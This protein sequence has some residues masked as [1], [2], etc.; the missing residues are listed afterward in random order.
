MSENKKRLTESKTF[1]MM[2]WIHMHGF[3]DGRVYP[4]CFGDYHQPLGNLRENT[5][6]EVW[7][8]E[9][10]KEL[11]KNMLNE[12]PSSVCAKCY[13]QEGTG[14]FSLRNSINQSH[15]KY[16]DEVDLTHE[17]GFHPEF[18]LRYWDVRFSNLCNFSCRSCSPVFSSN[19]FKEHVKMYGG[20]PQVDGRELNVVE[21][22]G[23]TKYDIW[24]QM[25]P[26]IPY[27]DQIYFAGGEPLIM[28]EHYM[29]LE[30]L[31]ELGK[32]DINLQYNTNFS[33]MSFKNKDVI[34]LWKQ[35]S[36]VNVGASL[37]G[38]HRR[39]ELIRRGQNWE[40]TV[41]NRRRMIEEVPHV[42]FHISATVSIMNVLHIVDFHREWVELGLIEP[43]DFDINV[44]HGPDHYR[45]DVL[46]DDLKRQVVEPKIRKHLEWLRPQDPVTRATIGYE[47]LLNS[48]F[49]KDN[50][51]LI[52]EFRK[53]IK[54]HDAARGE[55]FWN[56]F[57]ELRILKEEDSL[58]ILPWVSL[59]TSPVGT[60]R[61]CCLAE[62]EIV[63][64]D[65]N[66]M[67]LRDHGILDIFNSEYMQQLRKDFR[68]GKKPET[69]KKCWAE[70]S[71]GRNSK[72][73]NTLTK[74]KHDISDVEVHKDT[75]DNIKFL[76]LKLGNICNL[77]CR[78][79]GSWSSSKWAAEELD[80]EK[81]RG[82]SK[83]AVKQHFAYQMLREGSWPRNS[84]LFWESL[85]TLLPSV[86]YFEFTGGEPFM[87]QEH[88]DLLQ[89][90]ADLGYAENIGLHYNT[91]GTVYPEHFVETWK[92]FK[93]VEVAFSVDNV[94]ERFEYERY[95]ADWNAVNS[96]I[97]KFK[98][99]K[100]NCKNLELQ[101]CFTVNI[102]NVLYINELLSWAEDIGFDS[103]HWNMLHGPEELS[104]AS[105][106]DAVKQ[107]LIDSIN[108]NKYAA[109]N[110]SD[111]RNILSMIEN[112]SPLAL[113]YIHQ[114]INQTD[115]YRNQHLSDTHPEIARV[116][117]YEKT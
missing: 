83:E 7:N 55:D 107:D 15:G 43:K 2:P 31:I 60:A 111:V 52:P 53:Q 46:P 94:G 85:E 17:S 68:E 47:G 23:Q 22:A 27:L 82:A 65:G 16:V 80:Y 61:P 91:N 50:S 76:D 1:C 62:E 108:I 89:K 30:K 110:H 5:M 96:N 6:E 116:L 29:L 59:E 105:V 54:T 84:D 4:C 69:C 44:L 19:W 64:A 88:F 103:I 18:K 113:E 73:I 9:Q 10:Y 66:K 14:I 79:C 97:S 58:C 86:E 28:E 45:V 112:G 56:T 35:F 49:A 42:D 92:K 71:A 33:E 38:S 32:T 39:G 63:D 90:A 21:Y 106:P 40:Q 3:A 77:K 48:M 117:K 12:Q 20:K 67:H 95:L 8:N 26:H 37:D 81:E 87:I 74:F 11:R 78:I 109:K 93:R 101:L 99:L 100:E 102:F 36:N 72:R 13:E 114:K 75:I 25:Q 104:I 70:E 115:S 24:E 51:H 41:V 57:P 34:E 98:Q